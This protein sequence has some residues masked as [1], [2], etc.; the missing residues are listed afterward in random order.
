MVYCPISVTLFIMKAVI[1][2]GGGGMRLR[3]VTYEIPKPLIPVKKEPILNHVI[4]FLLRNGV[5]DFIIVASDRD[6]GDF[7]KWR[8]EWQK[9]LKVKSLK[10]F[11]E[12]KPY[13]TFGYVKYLLSQFNKQ[14]FLLVN[15]DCLIDFNL[16]ELYK[17]HVAHRF[18]ITKAILKNMSGYGDVGII[19]RGKL[20]KLN[21]QKNSHAVPYVDS[22][23]CIIESKFL[24]SYKFPVRHFLDMDSDI[25]PNLMRRGQV[26][27]KI[28]RR[29][30]F[31]D[32][33][34]LARWEKAI[35]NW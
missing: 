32:C 24:Q 30:R 17:F 20:I 29:S 9:K 8:F 1:L 10:F 7:I 34:T 33:G 28:M 22:G 16:S 35:K 2:A 12:E 21:T 14:P 5:R 19:K 6:R 4:G 18:V 31:F 26:G 3:P 25:I 13:G 15:G 23:F 11:Y 27:A